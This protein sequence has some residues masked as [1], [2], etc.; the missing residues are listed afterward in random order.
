[1]VLGKA[2]PHIKGVLIRMVDY[3]AALARLKDQAVKRCAE[4][5]QNEKYREISITN[6]LKSKYM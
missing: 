3:T 5:A 2:Y 4:R 6:K 1:M